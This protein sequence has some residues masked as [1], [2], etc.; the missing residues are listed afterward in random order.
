MIELAG[1]RRASKYALAHIPGLLYW[2]M[3][4]PALS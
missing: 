3:F 1:F 2:I 4:A